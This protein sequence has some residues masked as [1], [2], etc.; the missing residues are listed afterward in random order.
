M[1]VLPSTTIC[2][3]ACSTLPAQLGFIVMVHAENDAAIRRTKKRLIELGRTDIRYH[4]VAHSEIMEREATHRALA[5]AE[6]TGTRMTIVH[7]S[8]H[9]SGEEIERARQRGVDV[10]AETCPQYLFLG[11]SDLDRPARDAARFVFSPPT[12]SPRSHA[13]L[14]QALAD[15]GIDL[16]SSDHS[17]YYFADKIGKAETPGFDTT[18]SGIPGP[19]D[20][21][22][23]AFLR[24]PFGRPPVARPLSRP[25]VAQCR[26][27]LRPRSLQGPHRRR[28]RCGSGAVGSGARLDHRPCRPAFQCRLLALRRQAGDGQAGHR[29]GARRAGGRRREAAGPARLRTNSCRAALPIPHP[30][31][32]LSRRPRHGSRADHRGLPDRPDPE[33]RDAGRDGRPARRPAGAGGGRRRRNRGVSRDG[34][35]HLLSALAHRR[36]RRDRGVLRG[37][38]ARAR[39]AAPLRRRRAAED[40]LRA[41]LLAS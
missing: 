34:A 41:R 25:H 30:P 15:G 21:A 40:R 29:A 24:R 32:H 22:A 3:C 13:Y 39:D 1:T 33:K 7:V 18:L 38:H 19:G 4:V 23:A 37:G 26:R 11:S 27:D 14:W 20:Q 16:W 35:D 17:P 28:A 10:V 8:S 9:Q 5:L 36:H 6:M 2:S 12:R 31:N